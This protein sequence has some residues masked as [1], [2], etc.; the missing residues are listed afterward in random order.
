MFHST[1][2]PPSLSAWTVCICTRSSIG[3]RCRPESRYQTALFVPTDANRL[4][5][6]AL[7]TESWQCLNVPYRRTHDWHLYD[8]YQYIHWYVGLVVW[9]T[10]YS[11]IFFSCTLFRHRINSHKRQTLH[12]FS[13]TIQLSKFLRLYFPFATK[14]S[15]LVPGNILKPVKKYSPSGKF[16]W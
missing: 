2:F 12:Q 5:K 13:H 11:Y 4:E 6:L 1:F 7:L 16:W 8:R 14:Y 15:L 10:L 3:H 9:L